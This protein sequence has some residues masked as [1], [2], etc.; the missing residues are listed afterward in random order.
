MYSSVRTRLVLLWTLVVS[1]TLVAA[2]VAIVSPGE[3]EKFAAS[4]SSVSITVK[5]N[6]D[7]VTPLLSKVLG[8]QFLLCYGSNDEVICPDGLVD[9]A[10]LSDLEK[11]SETTYSYSASFSSSLVGNGQYFIQV[12]AQLSED[13]SQYTIHYTPRFTLSSMSGTATPTITTTSLPPPQTRYVTGTA[14]TSNDFDVSSLSTIPYTQQTWRSRFAPMQMQPGSTVTAT[15]WTRRFPTSAV[16]Y[17]STFRNWKSLEQLSTITPGWSYT[18]SSDFNYA[19]PMP[20]PSQNGG[21][22]NPKSRQSL[23]TRM[24]NLKYIT[25][26]ITS[27]ATSGSGSASTLTSS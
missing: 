14:T 21:W 17:Y 18:I 16:T 8:Y 19:T 25:K 4:G 7:H 6:E 26:G 15:T 12:F 24:R 11:G 22:Y 1:L 2:D 20:F 13:S 5:W 27:P 9:K 10:K 3:G 23:S